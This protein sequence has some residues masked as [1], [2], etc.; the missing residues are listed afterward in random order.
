MH[1]APQQTLHDAIRKH[2]SPV[3]GARHRLAQEVQVQED[4]D[5]V[6]LLQALAHVD[7][8][9]LNQLRQTCL[10]PR[11]WGE[12]D[13]RLDRLGSICLPVLD[14]MLRVLGGVG[15]ADGLISGLVRGVIGS[16]G[17]N[18][19]CSSFLVLLRDK[20]I[21]DLVQAS[22]DNVHL[23]QFVNALGLV[24]DD[25]LERAVEHTSE[26]HVLQFKMLKH[27][28]RQECQ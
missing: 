2:R 5:R 27:D 8:A 7:V 25:P 4:Q 1:A 16:G 23:L 18:S 6:L 13:V 17:A 14:A 24:L 20:G 28:N 10:G 9:A 26:T 22:L 19:H 21:L 15:T 3:H 12:S 11:L